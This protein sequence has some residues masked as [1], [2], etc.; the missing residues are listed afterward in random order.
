M[1]ADLG[2][3]ED[4]A[5]KPQHKWIVLHSSMAMKLPRRDPSGKPIMDRFGKEIFNVR[6]VEQ[7]EPVVLTAEL[8]DRLMEH[9]RG[10]K[11]R[12]KDF[13]DSQMPELSPSE[14][15]DESVN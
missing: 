14:M 2:M 9:G 8:V 3:N 13:D 15:A 10:R 4:M 12:A 11:P 5:T 7:N 1:S 6:S